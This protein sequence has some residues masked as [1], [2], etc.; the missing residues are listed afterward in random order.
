MKS[1]PEG[2]VVVVAVPVEQVHPLVHEGDLA[3]TADVASGQL[4]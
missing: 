2:V 4:L 3:E 1:M